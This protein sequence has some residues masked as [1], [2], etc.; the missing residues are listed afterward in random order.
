MKRIA[1]VGGDVTALLAAHCLAIRGHHVVIFHEVFKSGRVGN[2]ADT[3]PQIVRSSRRF[4][5]LLRGL[6]LIHSHYCTRVGMLLRDKIGLY[7]NC[8]RSLGREKATKVRS[9]LYLKSRLIAP[10][11]TDRLTDYEAIVPKSAVRFDWHEFVRVL[12][13][14]SRICTEKVVHIDQG[15]V[16][17][18]LLSYPFD[19]LVITLPLWQAKELVSWALPNSVS[20]P[21]N[22]VTV[23]PNRRDRFAAWDS[24][25]TPYT[26]ERLVHRVF[27]HEDGYHV[28]FSG[29]WTEETSDRLM[30]DLNYFFPGGWTVHYSDRNV[31]GY[32]F[33]L[34]DAPTWPSNVSPL[35][36]F[37][38][39][40]ELATLDVCL[41]K[42]LE[43]K[44]RWG[45]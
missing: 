1:I 11:S 3:R 28:Q 12:T 4:I 24:V 25:W 20:V 15:S 14:R 13:R 22:S 10:E 27:Q 33:P 18:N 42:V 39:W 30:G 26:P 6:G 8:V 35:G 7:P 34:V 2:E 43:L 9:D 38:S 23:S 44:Q 31:P 17:T 5:E 19:H 37:A 29:I 32:M 16:R 40:D 45:L 36:R 41:E 21:V